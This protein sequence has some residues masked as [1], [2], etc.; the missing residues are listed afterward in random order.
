MSRQYPSAMR[1]A[2]GDIV[3]HDDPYYGA[4]LWFE[5]R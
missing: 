1:A 4:S 3:A 2:F 5:V